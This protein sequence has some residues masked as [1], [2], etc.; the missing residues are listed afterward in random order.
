MAV[1]RND[2]EMID[3]N[4]PQRPIYIL[5]E[6]IKLS[7]ADTRFVDSRSSSNLSKGHMLES[8]HIYTSNIIGR[9]F[10]WEGI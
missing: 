10:I 6:V 5:S 9:V 4:H 3:V 1:N 8:S 7:Y 2:N